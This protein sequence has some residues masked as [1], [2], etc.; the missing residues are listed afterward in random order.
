MEIIK[1]KRSK[2]PKI[3]IHGEGGIGKSTLAASAPRP[4][5]IQ[6]EDGL[7]SIDADA[8]QICQSYNDIYQQLQHFY[9]NNKDMK[10]ETLVLDTLDWAEKLINE[11]VCKENKTE[12]I[13]DF[14]YGKGF[15][16]ASEKFEKIL[17][18]LDAI[19]KDC[20][21][22]IIL[23]AHTQVKTYQNPIG[24]NYDMFKIKLREKNSELF[25]EWVDLIGF[26]HFETFISTKKEGFKETKK[27]VGGSNRILSCY[28][29]A[30]WTAKN[31][32]S[33]TKDITINKATGISDLLNIIKKG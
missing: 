29:H 13:S 26:I 6:T 16:Y 4:L 19:A 27:A 28:P 25:I 2:P 7:S 20:N 17:K 24:E 14:N 30:A 11:S 32:Y 5:F 3:L 18:G 31:R 12:S 15:Q 10:Y 8:F 21:V 23:I 33:I 9:K 1:T 22:A